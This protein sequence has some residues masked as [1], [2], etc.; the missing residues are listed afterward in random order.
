MGYN[1]KLKGQ[2]RFD[3]PLSP[4]HKDFFFKI[5]NQRHENKC[6]PSFYCQWTVNE[7]GTII[8]YDGKEKFYG[9]KEWIG[10]INL[11]SELLGYKLMGEVFWVGENKN[12]IGKIKIKEGKIKIWSSNE[13]KKKKAL[14]IENISIDFVPF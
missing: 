9:F 12:D 1:T 13:N 5:T 3:K 6:L 14:N 11:F 10:I 7:N 4:E 8:I 2:F